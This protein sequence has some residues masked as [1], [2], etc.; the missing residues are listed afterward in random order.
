MGFPKMI[1]GAALSA[2][3]L[4]IPAF[5]QPNERQGQGQ[6]VVTIL[7]A[8]KGDEAP[9]NISQQDVAIKVNG[10]ESSVTRFTPLRG[11]NGRLELVVLM[12]SGARSSIGNQLSDIAS[13]IKSLP[14]DA[15][16]TVGAMQ[17]GIARLAGPLTA[18]HEAAAKGLRLPMG[19]P[20]SSASPY[21]CLSDLATH[22]PS[23]DQ[24]ARREV[25]MITDGV[26]YYHPTLDLD[27]PYV[28]AAIRD[29]ARAR[30]VIYS[31]YWQNRGRFDRTE[32]ANTI[33]QNLLQQVTQATGGNSYWI[34]M[35]NPVS[36]T[37]YLED[38][39]HRLKNQY[40]LSFI[41]PFGNKPEVAD[42][43]L[44]VNGIAGKVAAPG[45][46]FVSRAI[47]Q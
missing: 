22:W 13:F 23:N 30:L 28:N 16:V 4:C 10:K 47:Q 3:A 36:V 8:H 35:G 15:K 31:I 12:D 1:A 46:V 7:P 18:D 38:I 29:A 34:G 45:Q 20:G 11:E 14:P 6:A 41:A 44:K 33:G 39:G 24:S 17:N 40:E 32:Y 5:A 42:L 43:K 26:D 2:I 27:D 19:E 37:P 21:F 9:A 25:I